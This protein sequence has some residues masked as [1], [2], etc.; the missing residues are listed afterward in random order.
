MSSG[1]QCRDVREQEVVRLWRKSHIGEPSIMLY[2]EWVRRYRVYCNQYGLDEISELSEAGAIQFGKAYLS[3]LRVRGTTVSR[4][5]AADID[6]FIVKISSH[7]SRSTTADTASSLK[8][9][10]RFLQATGRLHQDLAACVTTPRVRRPERP[11][12]AL[13]WTEVRRIL[14]AIP[15]ISPPGK[16]DFAMLLMMTTYGL[17][18]AE[19]LGL[20]IEDVEWNTQVLRVRRPKT[21]IRVDLPLF[22]AVGKALGAYLKDE[23]PNHASARSIFLSRGIPHE[24]ITS[25]AIRHRIRHYARRA[26]VTADVFGAHIFRHSHASRQ[27][28]F[29]ADLKVVSD[30]LGHRRPSSTFLYVRVAFRRLR[31]VALPVP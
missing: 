12:R 10:L 1:I 6:D 9:F 4:M 26:G 27:I 7:V 25:G 19:V 17:G 11:P 28:D 8:S 21:Q 20:R 18:A 15:Q 3:S 16:R 13:P 24:P 2:L 14:K 22:P 29:G 30:I 31:L 5:A 23:R